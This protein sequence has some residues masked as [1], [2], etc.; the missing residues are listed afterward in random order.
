MSLLVSN[1]LTL[2]GIMPTYYVNERV[3]KRLKE[4]AK[5]K[6]L[7]ASEYHFGG[8]SFSDVLDELLKEVGF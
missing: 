7:I 4:W 6:P 2:G 1:V 3:E 8:Y 5:T